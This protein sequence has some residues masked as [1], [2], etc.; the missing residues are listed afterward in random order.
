MRFP[1]ILLVLSATVLL[2]NCNT[3]QKDPQMV[4]VSGTVLW[5]KYVTDDQ[6]DGDAGWLLV[7][8]HV[9]YILHNPPEEIANKC[10]MCKFKAKMQVRAIPTLMAVGRGYAR[11]N[12]VGVLDLQEEL[13]DH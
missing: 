11:V 3:P 6:P 8:E 7:T 13:C 5:D 10:S 9:R 12:V 1:A 4:E 2:L